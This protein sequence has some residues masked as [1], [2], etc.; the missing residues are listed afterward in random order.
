ML[1]DAASKIAEGFQ[2]LEG[3]INSNFNELRKSILA[4]S[5]ISTKLPNLVTLLCEAKQKDPAELHTEFQKYVEL[6]KYDNKKLKVTDKSKKLVEEY[7]K[8]SS[9]FR[10]ICDPVVNK[11]REDL[12]KLPVSINESDIKTSNAAK[13]TFSETFKQ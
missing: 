6:L 10:S 7:S 1:K 5:T 2:T 9:N 8:M 13:Y 3:K 4:Q 11:V 12:I